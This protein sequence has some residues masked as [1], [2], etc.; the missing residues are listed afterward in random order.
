[1]NKLYLFCL[2]MISAC[3]PTPNLNITNIKNNQYRDIVS[4]LRTEYN[5][6]DDSNM[7]NDE[8]I[9]HKLVATNQIF[10]KYENDITMTGLSIPHVYINVRHSKYFD[11]KKC[12]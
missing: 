6:I 3:N 2:I 5:A 1:M 7:S 9:F 11:C 4:V 12:R 8:I 10:Q